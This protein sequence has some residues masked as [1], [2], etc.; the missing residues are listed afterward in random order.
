MPVVCLGCVCV[1]CGGHL[2]LAGDKP[3]GKLCLCNF[4]MKE[5]QGEDTEILLCFGIDDVP[6]HQDARHAN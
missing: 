6:H 5:K 1:V 2:S 4:L 3:F